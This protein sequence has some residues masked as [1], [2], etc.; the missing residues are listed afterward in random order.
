MV[1]IDTLQ[2]AHP[3]VVTERDASA[4]NMCNSRI[5]VT[6]PNGNELQEIEQPLT[7]EQRLESVGATMDLSPLAVREILFSQ[8]NTPPS[9]IKDIRYGA[10]TPPPERIQLNIK[11]DMSPP[12][13]PDIRYGAVTPPPGMA[14][15]HS[16]EVVKQTSP[17]GRKKTLDN[18]N[19]QKTEEKPVN[20]ALKEKYQKLLEK[21]LKA[22]QQKKVPQKDGLKHRKMSYLTT[23]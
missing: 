3:K 7:Y 17:F 15:R 14:V 2:G 12:K 21:S 4:N 10:V 1:R 13:S 22:E 8:P 18:A 19:K 23:I 6:S 11:K 16:Q 20:F 5:I 9:D